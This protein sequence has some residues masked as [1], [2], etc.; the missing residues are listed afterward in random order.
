M[1]TP[2]PKP[3]RGGSRPNSGRK[4]EYSERMKPYTLLLP[5]EYRQWIEANGGAAYVRGLIERAIKEKRK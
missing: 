1:T 5:L 4:R 2:A 3:P